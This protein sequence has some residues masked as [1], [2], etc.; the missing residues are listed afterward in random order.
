M[1][2]VKTSLFSTTNVRFLC[3]TFHLH[4]TD[5]SIE[6][7]CTPRQREWKNEGITP[8]EPLETQKHIV[9][10]LFFS[11]GSHCHSHLFYDSQLKYPRFARFSL[12]LS[13]SQ[14]SFLISFVSAFFLRFACIGHCAFVTIFFNSLSRAQRPREEYEI[15][16]QRYQSTQQKNGCFYRNGGGGG[17]NGNRYLLFALDVFYAFRL[18]ILCACACNL[19]DL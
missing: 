14:F 7:H 15:A 5:S 10:V 19:S 2:T 1:R 18:F 8:E 11:T 16:N 9:R 17:D 12:W 4:W 6:C 3:I 13:L